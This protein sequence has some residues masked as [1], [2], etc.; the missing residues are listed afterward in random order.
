MKI[1]LLRDELG[2]IQEDI[3]RQKNSFKSKHHDII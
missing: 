1:Q 2:Q 3:D